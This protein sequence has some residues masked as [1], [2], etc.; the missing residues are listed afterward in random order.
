MAKGA[1]GEGETRDYDHLG[2]HP[3][4]QTEVSKV[5]GVQSPRHLPCHPSRNVQMVLGI[6]DEA[7]DIRRNTCM[8]INLPIFKDEDAKDAVI[9]QVGGGI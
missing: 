7:G 1:I 3:L 5:I 9:Y 2:F 4:H 6:Q 8:K